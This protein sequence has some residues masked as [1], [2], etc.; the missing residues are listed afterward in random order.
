MK[1]YYIAYG[2]NLNMMQM[3][4]RCK[5]AIAEGVGYLKDWEL[6]YAGSLTGN[7]AT[8][9]KK[10]GGVVPVGVW[11]IS[12]ENEDALDRYEGWP[13]FYGKKMIEVNMVTGRIGN[14]IKGLVYIMNPHAKEGQ[15]SPSYVD[16]CRRGYRDFGIAE[17]YLDESLI[18]AGIEDPYTEE[19]NQW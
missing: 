18:R 1:R 6:F 16:T 2:S 4:F 7:Y 19:W 15:P 13:H 5:G 17:K 11:R 14:K 3:R 12:D 10:K 9:R 8:I